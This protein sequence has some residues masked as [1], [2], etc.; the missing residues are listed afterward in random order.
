MDKIEKIMLKIQSVLTD[1][2][3]TKKYK[4][5]QR[6]TLTQGH[7]YAASEALYYLLG[8]EKEGY[9]PCVASFI[10]NYEKFTHWW[11]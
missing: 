6:K 2:L 8:G 5:L 10:E 4:K 3:L 11:I 9:T 1:D 7:C